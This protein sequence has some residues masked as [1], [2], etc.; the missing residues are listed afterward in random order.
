M[1]PLYIPFLRLST[2]TPGPIPPAPIPMG[3]GSAPLN[4]TLSQSSRFH[5]ARQPLP[6][7]V[8]F[9]PQPS[10]RVLNFIP[11]PNPLPKGRGSQRH[12]YMRYSPKRSVTATCSS[13]HSFFSALHAQ[14]IQMLPQSD[15]NPHPRVHP[16]LP[17]L[18][19]KGRDEGKELNFYRYAGISHNDHGDGTFHL[20]RLRRFLYFILII[21]RTAGALPLWYLHSS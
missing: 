21:Y 2:L 16:P 13:V 14:G 20:S 15:S 5:S 11:H 7:V 1:R 6:R 17:P 10:H 9:T 19:F 3:R 12:F 8:D 18:P 4:P